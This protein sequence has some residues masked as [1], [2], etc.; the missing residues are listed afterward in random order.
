MNTRA[1]IALTLLSTV[2][3][4]AGISGALSIALQL[5]GILDDCEA[6]NAGSRCYLVATPEPRP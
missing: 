3:I 6:A 5:A 2:A 4:L 1:T